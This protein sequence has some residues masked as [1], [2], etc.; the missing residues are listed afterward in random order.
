[1]ARVYNFS[2]G[3]SMLPEAVLCKAQADMLDYQGSGQSV[4]E[5]SHRSKWFAPIIEDTEAALRRVLNIPDDYEVG[6]FQGGATQQFA[7]VPLNFLTTGTADYLVTGNF[8]K[9]AAEEC[10]KFGTARIAASSK[11][12]NF[13]Y[14]PDLAQVEFDP[15]AS[16]IHICQNNTIF[17]TRF[18]ELPQVENV[19]LVADLSSMICSEPIDVT[20]YGCI[21]FGVQKNIAPAG[22]AVAIVRKDML[23]KAAK[24][25]EPEQI[26][27]MMNYTTLLKNDS[28]YNTPPCWCIYMT[29]LVLDWLEHEVGG[30]AEMQKINEAKAKVLY[31]YLDSQSFYKNPVEPRYRSMMNVTFTSPTP[32]LD[33]AFCAAAAKAGFVNLKGHRLVGG[34][35]ASIYNAMPAKAIPELVAFMEQFRKENA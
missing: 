13:T 33:A 15:N 9:K 6:F 25:M 19:P 2:A 35:R 3:P 34:M 17:G 23:G 28:M 21:Y 7:M 30:L 26:P 8:S 24:G 4:M 18:V 12:R 22:M 29:G 11:D 16:Y 20:R 10:A 14:I 32:E 5:M 1:M 27:T 31:D